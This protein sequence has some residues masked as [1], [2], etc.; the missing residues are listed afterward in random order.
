M[1]IEWL[2]QHCLS[3]PATE[4]EVKWEQSLC[5][6][7]A[8]KMFCLFGLDDSRISF[9]VPDDQFEELSGTDGFIPAPYLARA[10]WVTV[11][12]PEKIG[13]KEI[14]RL[15]RQS[16]ELIRD[17]LPKKVKAEYGL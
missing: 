6:M 10:R 12:Q 7:V 15:L 3:W 8:K 11:T 13:K 16:Y 2:Q 5:F 14:A 9:K 17:K 1:E 4:E